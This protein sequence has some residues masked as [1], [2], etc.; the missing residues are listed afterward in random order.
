MFSRFAVRTLV[1]VLRRSVHYSS[2]NG[3][4]MSFLKGGAVAFGMTACLMH[5]TAES[6]AV[7]MAE[8]RKDIEAAVDA[9][10]AKR[11]D[12]TSIAPTLIR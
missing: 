5:F 12:G 6:A 4:K 9:C 10:D 7:D 1:P 2:K 3:K 8:V 11:D